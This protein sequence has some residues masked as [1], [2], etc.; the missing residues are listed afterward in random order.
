MIKFKFKKSNVS[1]S[2]DYYQIMFDDN[3]EE[4]NETVDVEAILNSQ[5][6]YFL[7]QFDCEFPGKECYFESNDENLIGHYIVNYVAI[8][9]RTFT[10]KYGPKN[11]FIVTIEYCATDEE[12][13]E[14]INASKEMFEHV[15]V[16][17]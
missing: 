12:Q 17:S 8:N 3:L 11:K 1:I 16:N 15:N 6:P 4:A 9:Q 14:L 5:E 10:I 13:I 7:V 2:G